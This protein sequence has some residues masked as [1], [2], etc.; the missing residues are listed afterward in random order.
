MN[1]NELKQHIL[2]NYAATSDFPWAKYPNFE[3]F[4]HPGNKKWFALIMDVPREKL[5]LEGTETLDVVNVKCDPLMIST[6]RSEEGIFPAYHMS[7]SN[8]ITV[9]LDGSANDELIRILLDASFMATA[10]KTKRKAAPKN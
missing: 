1:R 10:P 5:G 4:R 3:V 7:K 9:A 2:G 6:L 8:W